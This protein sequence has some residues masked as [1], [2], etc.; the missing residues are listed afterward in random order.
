[1]AYST[2][3]EALE[4]ISSADPARYA[5]IEAVLLFDLTGDG[6]GKWTLALSS[7]GARLEEGE[8]ATP[9]RSMVTCW[10][11]CCGPSASVPRHCKDVGDSRRACYSPF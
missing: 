8:T 7:E 10:H 5:G 4:G 3:Q 6:G 2:A 1:M 11:R 9:A